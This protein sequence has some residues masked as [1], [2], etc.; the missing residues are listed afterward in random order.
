MNNIIEN[1]YILK[2]I[3]TDHPGRTVAP[4]AGD[5]SGRRFYRLAGGS[6]ASLVIMEYGEPFEDPT[7][8]MILTRIF[9]DAGLPVAGIV[10][11]CG[12]GGFLVLD[13]LGEHTLEQRLAELP[14]AGPEFYAGAVD[15]AARLADAGTAALDRSG[16][17]RSPALDQARFR[18]EMGYFLDHYYVGFLGNP[19]ADTH[20]QPLKAFVMELADQ[21]AAVQPTVLCHRDFHSR[22]LVVSRTGRLAMVDI[23]DG[24][25]GPLGYDLASLL[26]DA[27]VDLDA[28]LR[29]EMIALFREKTGQ[30]SSFETSL[31]TL[32][33]QRTLKALGTFGFQ[34][35]VMGRDRYRSAI[36]RTLVNIRDLAGDIAA[37]EPI[38]GT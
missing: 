7:D 24:R 3:E 23:Q 5:A 37:L 22:N 20:I 33:L 6:G 34:I 30:G 11:T 25:R 36:P 9:Q 12:E 27:Y 2:Y 17:S 38:I 21:A 18:F 19:D 13:D 15:L 31:R 28:G 29:Q 26:W 4:I 14:S 32:G 16:R 8:D 1:K 10:H 35:S